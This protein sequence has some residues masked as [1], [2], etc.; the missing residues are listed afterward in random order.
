MPISIEE[1]RPHLQA[2][3]FQG[4]FV[5]GLGWD[6]FQG[7]PLTIPV[8][9]HEYALKPVAKKADF[10]VLECGPTPDGAMPDYPLRRKIET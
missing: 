7:E 10:A 8:D 3:D 9:G 2:F 4:L 5:E 1:L 6:H